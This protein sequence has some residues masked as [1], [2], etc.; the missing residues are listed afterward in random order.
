MRAHGIV[1]HHHHDDDA[2]AHRHS[3]DH[4]AGIDHHADHEAGLN[5]PHPEVAPHDEPSLN[6]VSQPNTTHFAVVMVPP[7][8]NEVSFPTP[9]GERK[10]RIFSDEHPYATG[11]PGT[12]SSRAPPA[13]LTA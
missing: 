11:P 4:Q 8:A 6:S 12:R 2:P 3:T 10:R 9:I 5:D 1:P 7:N 13:S